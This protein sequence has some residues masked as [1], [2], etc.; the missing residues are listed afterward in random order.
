MTG[1]G[2]RLRWRDSQTESPSHI[3]VTAPFNKG[4]IAE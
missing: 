2:D 4:A 3:N 1:R